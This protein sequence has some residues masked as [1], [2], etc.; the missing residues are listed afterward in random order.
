MTALFDEVHYNRIIF[1]DQV[2]TK[3]YLTKAVD[4]FARYLDKNICSN[5]PIVYLIAPNHLKTI[6]AF[7]GI[8]KTDRATLLV[9]HESAFLNTKRCLPTLCRQ[10]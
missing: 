2:F 3:E 1:R 10:L 4:E 7:L 9:D 6:I 5:S 8:A